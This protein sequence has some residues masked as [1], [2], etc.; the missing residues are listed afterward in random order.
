MGKKLSEFVK[1]SAFKTDY[2]K[3][4]EE[5][6]FNGASSLIEFEIDFSDSQFGAISKGREMFLFPAQYIIH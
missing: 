1:L 3:Y 5:Y 2:F 4:F 6:R